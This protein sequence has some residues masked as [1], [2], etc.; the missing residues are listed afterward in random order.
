A[1]LV[2]RKSER[3]LEQIV[4]RGLRIMFPL[5]VNE[6][7]WKANLDAIGDIRRNRPSSC[8]FDF[9]FIVEHRRFDS[10]Y[11]Q[12]REEGYLIGEGDTSKAK[13]TG[14]LI[15]VDADPSRVP[16]L[17]IAWPV[18]IFEQGSFP[19]ITAIDVTSLPRYSLLTS[20]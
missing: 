18:Q 8:S 10:F 17:D 11:R 2:A 14:D 7:I 20:F 15:P 13:A 9:L 5:R 19:D 6:A 16:N 1:V 4:G 12:L 3:L